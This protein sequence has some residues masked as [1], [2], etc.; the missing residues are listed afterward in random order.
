MALSQCERKTTNGTQHIIIY[1]V[2]TVEIAIAG[3]VEQ[4]QKLFPV[5]PATLLVPAARLLFQPSDN[6]L[7]K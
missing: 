1:L 5:R 7:G 6:H 2:F 3:V 4:L